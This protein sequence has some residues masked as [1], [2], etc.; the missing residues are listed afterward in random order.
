METQKKLQSIIREYRE[1]SGYSQEE[2][3]AI[4]GKSSKYIGSVECGRIKPPFHVL[5]KIVCV[6]GIDA[7]ILFYD[8]VDADALNTAKICLSRMSRSNQ[9]IA[10]ELLQTMARS[11]TNQDE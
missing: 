10:L 4:I 6:L 11:K 1:K 5:K 3:S 8:N 9:Q 2:L 7:N